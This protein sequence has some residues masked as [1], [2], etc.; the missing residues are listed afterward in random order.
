MDDTVTFEPHWGTV[1]GNTPQYCTTCET[2][3]VGLHWVYWVAPLSSKH[4]T[5]EACAEALLVDA[6]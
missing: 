6:A 5:C 3:S 1:D 2:L 4:A